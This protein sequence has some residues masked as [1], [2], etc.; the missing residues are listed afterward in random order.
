L[1]P[2][3]GRRQVTA[4]SYDLVGSTRLSSLLDPEDF[5]ELQHAFHVVCLR[6]VHQFGGH[7]DDI[8]GDGGLVYFG[9]P[10]AHED[11][12]ERAVR[13]GL[14]I[15]SGCGPLNEEAVAKGGAVAVRVGIATGLVVV[16]DYAPGE[17]AGRGDVVGL[18]PNLAFK[19]QKA[20]ESNSLLISA[21]THELAGAQFEYTDVGEIPLAGIDTPQ[22]AW[23]V[24]R[25][26]PFALRFQAT[27]MKTMA[28]LV[29]REEEL[30][31]I[32]HRW[33]LA[34]KSE[35]QV[36][37]ISGEPGIGKSRLAD[38]AKYALAA[39]GC[40]RLSLQCSAQ[41]ANTALYPL[42]SRLDHALEMAPS[43]WPTDKVDRLERLL[44]QVFPEVEEVVPLIAHLLEIPTEKQ[45]PPLDLNPERMRERLQRFLMDVVV[46]LGTQHPWLIVVEDLQWID[47]T[48]EELLNLLVDQVQRLPGML[49]L[50]FRPE[51]AARW[52]GQ[53][54]VS[55]LTL[56][57]LSRRHSASIIK[58][59]ASEHG[60]PSGVVEEII[61]KA[62][63]IPLF[64][65]ELTQLVVEASTRPNLPGGRFEP[66]R[67]MA[68]PATLYDSLMARLDQV[69]SGKEIVQAG[70][71]IGRRFSLELACRV[72]DLD[73]ASA[74]VTL[75]K[76]VA[77]GLA[78]A[79]R[80]GPRGVYVFK[81]ALVQEAAHQSMLR[82]R[83]QAVHRR[84]AEVLKA[85]FAGTREAEPEV[86]AHHFI[87]AGM[88]REAVTSLH[89]AGRFAAEK[90]ASVEAVRLLE[91]ALKLL[92]KLPEN[93][94]RDEIELSLLISLGPVQITTAGPGA[95]EAKST[96]RRAVELCDKLP[97]APLHFT[98][99]WGW[100]RTSP[101]FKDM[102]DRANRL[103][104]LANTL[105][106]AQLRLQAHH[107]QWATLFM[108][109]EQQTCCEHI[110]QGIKIYDEGDYRLHGVLYGGHDPKVCGLGERGLSMWL[111]GYPEQALQAS[112]AGVA[113]ANGLQ[114]TGSI[115]HAMDQEIMLHHYCQDGA[116]VRNRAEAMKAFGEEQA[117]RDLA[118]KSQIFKGWALA[119]S[120]DPVGG[121][122]LIMNGL[123]VQRAIGTQEDFPVYFCMLAETFGALGQYAEGLALLNEA[124]EMAERTGL[125]YW[126]AELFRQKG[127]LT[128][129][130]S[131]ADDKA[132]A[133]L[134]RAIAIAEAQ[135]ARS[136]LLRARASHAVLLAK[137]GRRSEAAESMRSVYAAF[138]EGFETA[139]LRRARDLL[140][141]LGRESA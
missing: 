125:Q 136:L 47:P 83:R 85:E 116:V 123:A 124:I 140:E 72:V 141:Q 36:V 59:V 89:E 138:T 4:L 29:S 132:A 43:D 10:Q 105:N 32:T 63:G 79:D 81:H 130:Q 7:V 70:S 96:Y 133:C 100:W 9:F 42:S 74:A 22:R 113:H 37:M 6:A 13:A 50:T 102:H 103:F 11:D 129:L 135:S 109:G 40:F 115:G 76:L 5:A 12:A 15:L 8:K 94:E 75:D 16:G 126:S 48:T 88:F 87:E 27:R 101:T 31:I 18:A 91:R 106:D 30:D 69:G 95:P 62:D 19:L 92:S 60:L 84:I 117:S 122:Q 111:L 34:S 28:P 61:D 112:A 99:Y 39:D 23:R 90:S 98:A 21:A 68:I 131:G 139:D 26:R 1:G 86:L 65:E 93:G 97:R 53:A 25:E 77:L 35:G 20:A 114:H 17:G 107:C 3:V 119:E 58:Y 52:V 80:R 2:A 14:E 46:H 51:Y 128:M 137:R 104:V 54:H 134:E 49:L 110:A 73:A 41:H 121:I 45:Y 118:S 71:A 44:V 127:V 57:R 82:T 56:N 66:P 64:I 55:L 120:G 33:L 78:T 24:L 38:T 108:L 67:T